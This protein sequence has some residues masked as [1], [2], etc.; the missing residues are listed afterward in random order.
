MVFFAIKLF[1]E[2]CRLF[3]TRAR[4]VGLVDTARAIAEPAEALEAVG[5]GV[6]GSKSEGFELAS[7]RCYFGGIISGINRE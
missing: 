2:I 1:W 7:F 6:T 4:A 3:I 5:F